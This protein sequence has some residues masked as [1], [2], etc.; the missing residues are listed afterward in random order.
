MNY[1]DNESGKFPNDIY[2]L[3]HFYACVFNNNSFQINHN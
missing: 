1:K 2:H 3:L